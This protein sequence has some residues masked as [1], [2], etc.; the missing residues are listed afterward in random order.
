MIIPRKIRDKITSPMMAWGWT[1]NNF[2]RRWD[3]IMDSMHMSLSKLRELVMDREAWC[4]KGL[5]KPVSMGLQRVGHDWTEWN[6]KSVSIGNHSIAYI[7]CLHLVSRTLW[8]LLSIYPIY[9]A[10]SILV[11]GTVLVSGDTD[12]NEKLS[13]SLGTLSWFIFFLFFFF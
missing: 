8:K 12:I 3:G 6:W 9:L 7:V 10:L 4:A 5:S 13:L 1:V 11:L 2:M